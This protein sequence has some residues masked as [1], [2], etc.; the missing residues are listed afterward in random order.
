MRVNEASKKC[1]YKFYALIS[2]ELLRIMVV[3]KIDR[4]EAFEADSIKIKVP[5]TQR[6]VVKAT[7]LKNF[8]T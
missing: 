2:I 7:R 5:Q 3:V 4:K 1:K 6:Q 8:P